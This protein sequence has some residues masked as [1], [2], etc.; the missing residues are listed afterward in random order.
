MNRLN[1]REYIFLLFCK[2]HRFIITNIF[3][4]RFGHE[5]VI[6]NDFYLAI[7]NIH[8]GRTTE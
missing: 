3:H 6:F 7:M 2:N 8:F 1:A 4:T 5:I